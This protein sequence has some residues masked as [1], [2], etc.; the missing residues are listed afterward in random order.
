MK[1]S[2]GG[3]GRIEDFEPFVFEGRKVVRKTSS[4]ED[5]GRANDIL[6]ISLALL[7]LG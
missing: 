7:M 6:V 2:F 4:A 5:Q 1:V 3:Q